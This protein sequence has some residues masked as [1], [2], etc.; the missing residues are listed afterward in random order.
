[1]FGDAE[2]RE[3]TRVEVAARA[4]LSFGELLALLTLTPGVCLRCEDLDDDG[5]V[6]YAVWFG[7][8]AS[9]VTALDAA[10]EL[11]VDALLDRVRKGHSQVPPLEYLHAAAR[12]VTRVFGV[13]APTAH[14][15][16]A[17]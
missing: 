14:L 11:A 17:A 4:Y 13:P 1:M 3:P 8:L 10:A 15:A 6:R 5:E 7:M 12:A 16:G 2:S 9:D